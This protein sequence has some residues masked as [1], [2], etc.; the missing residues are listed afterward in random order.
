[1]LGTAKRLSALK[2]HFMISKQQMAG[3]DTNWP[4]SKPVQTAIQHTR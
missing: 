2:S 3:S 1:V 4:H